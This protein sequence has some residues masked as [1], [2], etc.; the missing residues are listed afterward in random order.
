MGWEAGN[1]VVQREACSQKL[2]E[3]MGSESHHA[4]GVV[5]S[6]HI[7]RTSA[8]HQAIKQLG[9]SLAIAHVFCLRFPGQAQCAP[10]THRSQRSLSLGFGFVKFTQDVADHRNTFPS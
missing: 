8:A 1:R 2:N 4:W 3:L 10:V 6:P 5:K 7:L 9:C